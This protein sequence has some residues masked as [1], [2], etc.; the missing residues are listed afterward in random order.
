MPVS[1]ELRPQI[2]EE[3]DQALKELE[4]CPMTY[5]SLEPILNRASQRMSRLTVES[6]TKAASPKEAFS[7]SGV[8]PLRAGE[9]RQP[10]HAAQDS[11]H[12]ERPD[13]V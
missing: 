2:L 3:F 9:D 7:P 13:P 12:L 4:D 6:L 5:G 11:D 1:E 10:G 8:P